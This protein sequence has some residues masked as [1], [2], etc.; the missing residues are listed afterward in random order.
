MIAQR[1]TNSKSIQQDQKR[2]LIHFDRERGNTEL[3][4]FVAFE[5]GVVEG[6][7]G[8][9]VPGGGKKRGIHYFRISTR[10]KDTEKHNEHDMPNRKRCITLSMPLIARENLNPFISEKRLGLTGNTPQMLKPLE[11]QR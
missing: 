11:R 1:R 10:A 5:E 2:D 4:F 8:I 6:S 7:I 3:S 9:E